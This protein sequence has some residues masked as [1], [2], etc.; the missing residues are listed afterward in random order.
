MSDEQGVDVHVLVVSSSQG[1]DDIAGPAVVD[2]LEAAGHTVADRF[3]VAMD[4]AQL[5]E[6]VRLL[7][8]SEA[9]AVVIIGGTTLF[10]GSVAQEALAPL[11]CPRFESFPTLVRHLTHRSVG[12]QALW[13]EAFAGLVGRT[14]VFA[15]PPA[16]DICA[17]I[18]TDLIAPQLQAAVGLGL[19]HGDAPPGLPAA[20]VAPVDAYAELP[21]DPVTQDAIFEDLPDSSGSPAEGDEP[22]PP[23]SG[24]LGHLGRSEL[25]FSVSGT[26]DAEAPAADTNALP[27]AGW[28]RAVHEIGGTVHYDKREEMPQPVEQFAPLLDVLH[29]AGESAVLSLPSGVKYSL[30]GYP[31]LRR[32][33]A[34]VLALGWG[35]PLCELLAL[36]RY[37]IQT[38]TCIDGAHGLL[39][40]A[41]ADVAEVAEA[42][43]GRKPLDTRGVLF[44]V[45]RDAIYVQ[46]GDRVFRF[47][48]RKEQDQGTTKQALATLV[49]GW[50]QR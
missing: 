26:P 39:P 7:A 19:A 10:E 35:K 23:P 18:V 50:S 6:A 17:Q 21:D 5:R 44:A 9:P 43:T 40:H 24:S 46:R 12:S 14:A 20:A 27:G 34:K 2:A 30:W 31:D 38:G 13:L 3:V 11:V 8:V 45:E 4:V 36:H 29:Q 49:L 41:D 33:T 32:P 47:D 16:A 1:R 37:P 42:V 15:L 25:S 22:L 28:V 48:G